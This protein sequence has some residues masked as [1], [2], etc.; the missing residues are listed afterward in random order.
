MKTRSRL[1]SRKALGL[2]PSS[3]AQT[4]QTTELSNGLRLAATRVSGTA[5]VDLV[6]ALRAGSRYER[7]E[8]NGM[9]HFVEHMLFRGSRKFPSSHELN[10]AL[11]S[12]GNGLEGGT[13]R[14]YTLYSTHLPPENLGPALSILGDLF[15]Q[16]L[17]TGLETEKGIVL[18]EILEELDEK[19]RESDLDNLCR[20]M[21]FGNHP[22]GQPILGREHQLRSVTRKSVESFFREYYRPDNMVI[23]AAGN[24]R[25]DEFFEKVSRV[26]G[27]MPGPARG[28][29]RGQGRSRG[30]AA[31]PSL[32]SSSRSG[33]ILAP[34]RKG[35]VASE[36]PILFRSKPSS[37]IEV[38]LS[39]LAEGE[40][41]PY[42]LTQIA[43]ERV[44]DDGLSSR[45]QRRLCEK[46][47]L[48]YDIS[49]SVDSYSDAGVFDFSFRIAEERGVVAMQEVFK[50]V[51][52]L[53]N[54]LVEPEE[55]ARIKG[56]MQR[57]ALLLFESTR[58]LA[59]RIAETLLLELGTPLNYPEWR[60]GI[61]SIQAEDIHALARKLFVPE[62]RVA[63]IEGQV[64]R[65]D[66][67]KLRKLI[68]TAL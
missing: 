62:R 61:R 8:Q 60:E 39:F 48:L 16:P 38:L 26:F 24:I 67:R 68:E 41:S 37:Q 5:F 34:F 32:K 54:R 21:V 65:S 53:K 22:L 23:V 6:I 28:P 42:Y 47:G 49:A 2:N 58:H 45:L 59:G 18:E 36:D 29:A 7:P 15:T 4:I 57:E 27:Q 40:R 63:V 56:R 30:A 43:L 20:K 13:T 1:S 50:E 25:P 3:R 35:S 14:E 51:V 10:H 12:L 52:D 64:P 11:E 44:F 46:K 55:L 9:S 33:L 31:L 66:Q 19:G 17:F